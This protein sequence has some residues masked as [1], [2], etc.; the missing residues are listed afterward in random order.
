MDTEYDN[1]LTCYICA[2]EAECYGSKLQHENVNT[3]I[4]DMKM[5]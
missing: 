5:K 4:D 2:M 1:V 3:K